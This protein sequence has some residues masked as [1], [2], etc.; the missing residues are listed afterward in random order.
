M[1]LMLH[2]THLVDNQLILAMIIYRS[3]QFFLLVAF[4]TNYDIII[5]N[6]RY[7]IISPNPISVQVD[8]V[9]LRFYIIELTGRL[10]V[11]LG[12]FTIKPFADVVSDYLCHDCKNKIKKNFQTYNLLPLLEWVGETDNKIIIV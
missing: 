10:T 9:F 5:S 6:K 4:V 8:G 11:F 2:K 7:F 3:K 12:K 1:D